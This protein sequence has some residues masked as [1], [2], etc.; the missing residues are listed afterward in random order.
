M[1]KP[2]PSILIV[3]DDPDIVCVVQTYLEGAAYQVDTA[4]DGITGLALA[5]D[6]YP[7]LIVLDWMLPG[8]D[9]LEFMKRLR[10]EQRTP[11]IML[12]ARSEESD[13]I[14]GLDAG[15]DDYVSKPFSPRELVARVKAM[16][17]RDEMLTGR[18]Q[19]LIKRASLVIDPSSRSVTVGEREIALTS[20]EFDLLYTLASQPGR[21]FRRD[22]LLERVWGNDFGGVDRVVDVHISNLRQKI[23]GASPGAPVLMTV[24][25]VG[26]KFREDHK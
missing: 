17:R 25:G 5:L 4:L 9:G 18:P 2:V 1:P 20:L 12:T 6:R 24:R 10:R 14:I 16:L 15:A 23:E 11:V 8:L 19:D 26:Y 22:E 7:N 21:V 3:E 13:R